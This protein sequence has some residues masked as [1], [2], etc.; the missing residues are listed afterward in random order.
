MKNKTYTVE[1]LYCGA[2]EREEVEWF[3]NDN[4]VII[5]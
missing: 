4:D 1:R 3:N 5:Y 2:K